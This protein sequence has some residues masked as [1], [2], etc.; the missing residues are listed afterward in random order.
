MTN[1]EKEKRAFKWKSEESRARA[2]A[3]GAAN[4]A[5]YNATHSTTGI[6]SFLNS[7]KLPAQIQERLD[8]FQSGLISDLGGDE[9]VT[10]GQ[11]ALI[12]SARISLG[13][14]LLGFNYLFQEPSKL[15]KHRWLL[16]SLGSYQNSL[17]LTLTTL[18]LQRR[19]KQIESLDDVVAEIA[20]KRATASPE[21]APVENVAEKVESHV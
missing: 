3:A 15:R 17:R 7:G 8:D 21:A 16:A 20:A 6:S 18:G 2:A 11:R 19:A 4:L 9:S 14:I 10:T 5:K 13:V 1:K 12:Q